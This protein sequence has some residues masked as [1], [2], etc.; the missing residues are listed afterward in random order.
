MPTS[1]PDL[2]SR[3]IA[4]YID[5]LG[6][7]ISVVNGIQD[8]TSMEGMTPEAIAILQ[9]AQQAAQQAGLSQIV[10]TAGRGGGHLSHSQGTEWDIKGINPDGSLWTP[11]Q[12]VAVAEGARAAGADRFGLYNMENGL[13][14]GTLH[15][16]YSGPGRPAA[17]W[18]AN[19]LTSGA[20]SRNFTN[21]YEQAFLKGYQSG[22]RVSAYTPMAARTTTAQQP[23]QQAP[24]GGFLGGLFS[25]GKSFLNSPQ[26]KALGYLP[27]GILMPFGPKAANAAMGARGRAY[28]QA[29]TYLNNGA[30][31]AS[32]APAEPSRPSWAPAGSTYTPAVANPGPSG[33]PNYGYWA[34]DNTT[35]YQ[36][37]NG[38]V[39][40]IN[41]GPPVGAYAGLDPVEF[42]QANAQSVPSGGG[43]AGAVASFFGY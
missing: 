5:Q 1:T 37:N 28:E 20:A 41:T 18:G 38:N 33:G 26:G 9:G 40:S 22:G 42:G 32:A 12:R 15:M 31:A 7:P 16:G 11:D 25:L 21:P 3:T 17:V 13:G 24:K 30:A 39:Y 29:N 10:V 8:R 35:A 6:T 14:K 36:A 19:G 43:L 34:N 2:S 23:A 4:G 27:A